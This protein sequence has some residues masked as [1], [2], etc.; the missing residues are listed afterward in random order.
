MVMRAWPKALGALY[1]SSTTSSGSSTSRVW[2]PFEPPEAWLR[3]GL[4]LASFPLEHGWESHDYDTRTHADGTLEYR[5]LVAWTLRP[6]TSDHGRAPSLGRERQGATQHR[7]LPER[8]REAAQRALA[9]LILARQADLLLN[10]LPEGRLE[11]ASFEHCQ[12][13]AGCVRGLI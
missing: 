8:Y 6:A 5:T 3:K 7:W 12:V 2:K 10:R 1:G 13:I 11:G 9:R 4:L